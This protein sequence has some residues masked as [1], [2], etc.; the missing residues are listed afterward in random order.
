MPDKRVDAKA[1]LEKHRWSRRYGWQSPVADVRSELYDAL[2]QTLARME[3]LDT[4]V[5]KLAAEI[6]RACPPG[7]IVKR[8]VLDCKGAALADRGRTDG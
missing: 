6:E 5:L 3:A 7:Q 2:R 1:V 8:W 4:D